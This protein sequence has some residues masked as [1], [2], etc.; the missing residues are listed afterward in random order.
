[1]KPNDKNKKRCPAC[2][3]PWDECICDLPFDE[4]DLIDR[5]DDISFSAIDFE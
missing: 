3:L 1:M 5:D 4:Q 2:G